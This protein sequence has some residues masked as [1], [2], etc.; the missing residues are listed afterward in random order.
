MYSI[1]SLGLTLVTKA[2]VDGPLT[3][4]GHIALDFPT[5]FK[6]DGETKEL[7]PPGEWLPLPKQGVICIDTGC[8]KGGR[9]T[10]MIIDGD[11]FRLESV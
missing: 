9:L 6:G 11:R 1:V 4:V 3:V 5:W 2:L 7:L 10:A 8:S